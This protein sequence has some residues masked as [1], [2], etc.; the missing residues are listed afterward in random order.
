MSNAEIDL[1]R[2]PRTIKVEIR[3]HCRFPH[4]D[5]SQREKFLSDGEFFDVK[6]FLNV[7]CVVVGVFVVVV[8]VNVQKCF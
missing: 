1:G 3:T 5:P 4:S 8:V 7:V 6:W 2:F